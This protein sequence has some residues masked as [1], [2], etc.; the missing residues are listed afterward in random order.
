[1][2]AEQITPQASSEASPENEELEL[3]R[4]LDEFESMLKYLQDD[5]KEK[6]GQLKTGDIKNVVVNYGSNS[7]RRLYRCK[8]RFAEYDNKLHPNQDLPKNAELAKRVK[9][10]RSTNIEP[11]FRGFDAI[12]IE[13]LPTLVEEMDERIR[14]FQ[15][16]V[17]E[18]SKESKKVIRKFNQIKDDPSASTKQ[19]QKILESL[20][21]YRTQ[22]EGVSHNVIPWEDGIDQIISLA[23]LKNGTSQIPME[24]HDMR[25]RYRKVVSDINSQFDSMSAYINV[26][27]TL[28]KS[29]NL[30]EIED[31]MNK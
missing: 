6:Q 30:M 20:Y 12:G 3:V 7:A 17:T 15:K 16:M 11:L 27:E 18:Y 28:Q 4:A 1:M 21:L 26:A 23:V 2:A 5:L 24:Y 29:K 10:A 31:E 22:I 25:L 9:L 13:I 8:A 14:D 19:V